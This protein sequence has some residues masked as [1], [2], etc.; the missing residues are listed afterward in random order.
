MTTVE[1]PKTK[2]TPTGDPHY[3]ATGERVKAAVRELQQEGVS[4]I[5]ADGYVEMPEAANAL[6]RTPATP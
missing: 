4:I 1:V 3:S 5:R 6:G 2:Q